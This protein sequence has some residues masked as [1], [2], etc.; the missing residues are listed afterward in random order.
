MKHKHQ[1]KLGAHGSVYVCK[2]GAFRHANTDN[3]IVE[4]PAIHHFY[5]CGGCCNYHPLGWQGDCRNDKKRW[6]GDELDK[7]FGDKWDEVDE[8]SGVAN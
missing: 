7:T 3:A 8:E 2:C 4:V 5:L 6:T 1:F